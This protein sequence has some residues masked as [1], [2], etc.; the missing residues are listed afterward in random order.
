MLD[1]LLWDR[2]R[3]GN[4]RGR[5]HQLKSPNSARWSNRKAGGSLSNREIRAA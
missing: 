3:L 5:E 4:G 2:M 1:Q